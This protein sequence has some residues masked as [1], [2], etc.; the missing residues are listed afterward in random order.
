MKKPF[1]LK[2]F[3]FASFGISGY[4]LL[5]GAL[6]LN[7][8]LQGPGFFSA[9]SLSSLFSS[10]LPLILASLSQMVIMVSGG[11]DIS[12][13]NVMALVN[14]MAIMLS[15]S[16]ELPIAG[17]WMIALLAAT[18]V[19]LV[20]GLV[21]AFLRIPPLLATFAM[22]ILL[23]GISLIVLP[24]PGGTI[25]AIIYR[26]YGGAILGIPT[27]LWILV[28]ITMFIMAAAK[29]KFGRHIIAL[30]SHERNAYISGIHVEKIKIC[31]YT[32][33]G[34]IAGLA[35]LCLTALTASGDVRVGETFALQSIAAVIIGG[36]LGSGKWI[37]NT[38]GAICGA[39]FLAVVNNIVF[40][41][42]II[43]MR[44]NPGMRISTFYQQFLSNFI[45][46]FGLASAVLTGKS[47]SGAGGFSRRKRGR[48]H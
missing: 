19:G 5:F 3:S 33:G 30:G 2:H 46:I 32:F 24:R 41:A 44:S 9:G 14:G 21:I 34:F 12:T 18:T 36:S 1:I 25:P 17:S 39:L 37:R 16:M 48:Q 11:I 38:L 27:T 20:N 8:I 43:L 29:F 10:N 45:I 40:F 26:T 13:G 47:N 4:V 22:S 28:I 35:G 6:I 42:F 15:N 23:R 7:I 31:S